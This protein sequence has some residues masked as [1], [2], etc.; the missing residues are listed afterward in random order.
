ME[1]QIRTK[2]EKAVF[3]DSNAVFRV[4]LENS[5]KQFENVRA[6]ATINRS[7]SLNVALKAIN[8]N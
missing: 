4:N 7:S 5:K 1:K 8:S 2:F 6:A 3:C